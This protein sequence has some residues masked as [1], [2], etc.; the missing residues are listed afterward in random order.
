MAGSYEVDLF[1]FLAVAGCFVCC[2]CYDDEDEYIFAISSFQIMLLMWMGGEKGV[3][4]V[5][6][7]RYLGMCAYVTCYSKLDESWYI[8]KLYEIMKS[9]DK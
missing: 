4:W 5:K 6:N 7:F 9:I 1:F 3:L 8:A 2:L